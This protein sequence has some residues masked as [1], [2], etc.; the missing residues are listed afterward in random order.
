VEAR[1][2]LERFLTEHFVLAV[3]LGLFAGAFSFFT[4]LALTKN[5]PFLLG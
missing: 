3:Y 2:K 5:D 4:A 1:T